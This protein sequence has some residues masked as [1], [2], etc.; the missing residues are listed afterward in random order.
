M[1]KPVRLTI[2]SPTFSTTHDQPTANLASG[3]SQIRRFSLNGVPN[4]TGWAWS[5]GELLGWGLRNAVGIALSRSGE[6]L[7]EVENSSDNV[8]WQNVDVHQDNPGERTLVR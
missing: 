1:K 3:R 2:P 5:Q 4:G 8:A 6:D 7:W